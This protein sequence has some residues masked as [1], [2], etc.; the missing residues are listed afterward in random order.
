MKLYI[1]RGLDD[2]EIPWDITHVIVENK[3]TVVK[4]RAFFARMNL[5]SVI[6]GDKLK[7]IE[8]SAFPNCCYIRFIRLS[9]TLEYIEMFAFYLCE[10]LEA[11]FLPS[12]L[13]SI[14]IW[15]FYDC[16]SMRLL[17]LPNGINL[18]NIH[19]DIIFRTIIQQTAANAGVSYE[20]DDD[21]GIARIGKTGLVMRVSTE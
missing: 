11:L 16:Q 13:I 9:K 21:D 15:A 3:V 12:T 8:V 10:S 5:V 20:F 19:H 2:E 6:M 17:I 7:R 14:E 18:S 1:Y 4:A